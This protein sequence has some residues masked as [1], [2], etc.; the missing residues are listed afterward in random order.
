M[1]NKEINLLRGLLTSELVRLV[2]CLDPNG[3]VTSSN[4][5]VMEVTETLKTLNEMYHQQNA[6]Y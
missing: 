3:A 2:D 1:T 5:K 4:Q 6:K